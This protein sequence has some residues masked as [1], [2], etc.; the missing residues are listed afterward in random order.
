[1]GICCSQLWVSS[2]MLLVGIAPV[3]G[4]N[5]NGIGGSGVIQAREEPQAIGKRRKN[6]PDALLGVQRMSF[7]PVLVSP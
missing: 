1:M 6:H 2:L 7:A 5:R 3:C 4:Q